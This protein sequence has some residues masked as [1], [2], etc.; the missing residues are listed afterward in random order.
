MEELGT[1]VRMRDFTYELPDE[2]IAKY[3][4]KKRDQSKLLVY[5]G[6]TIGHRLFTQLPDLLQPLSLMVYNNT[7]VIQARL[8]FFKES[9]ARIEIF[10]LEPEMPKDYE[11]SFA[12]RLS[13]TWRCLIGNAKKWKQGSLSQ[14]VTIRNQ[15]VQLTA[16][17]SDSKAVDNCIDFTWDNA[18]V[19]F[20][21]ILEH[22]GLTPLPPYLNRAAQTGDSQWYQTIYA[23]PEGSVAAPTAGLHFTDAVLHKLDD[24]NIRRQPLTLHVGAGTFTP[25]KTETIGQHEMHTERISIQKELIWDLLNHAEFGV[26]AVG[27]TSMRSLE[28]LYWYAYLVSTGQIAAGDETTISQWLPYQLT[29]QISTPKVLQGLLGEMNDQ[30]LE[31]LDFL[32]QI[33]IIPGYQFRVVD[34]LITNFHQPNSTLLLLVAAFIGDDWKEVYQ[35]ALDHD[36]R[37]LSYG[38]SSIL[39]PAQR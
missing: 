19:S 33:I 16:S 39:I 11:S 28:S 17:R 6:G 26:T 9:G 3:P 38:D 12:A 31:S 29:E 32:T 21:E 10:C 34:Q 2:K 37:F 13:C 5:K 7:K 20:S 25:V 24:K 30:D 18:D 27:T 1:M 14:S 8:V 22:T 35:Y 36:F 23:E 4:V 15:V